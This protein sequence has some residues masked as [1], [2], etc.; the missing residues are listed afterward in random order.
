V[1]DFARPLRLELAPADLALLCREAAAAAATDP[2]P[3]IRVDAEPITVITDAERLRAALINILANA[4]QAT[5]ASAGSA[6]GRGDAVELTAGGS[7]N[8]RVRIAVRDRGAGIPPEHL[9][10]IFEPYFT[11]RRTGTGLGLPIARN[12]IEGLGGSVSVRAAEPGTIVEI[13]LPLAAAEAAVHEAR[14]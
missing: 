4:R 12:I 10:H 11:T 1:L 8:G 2:S 5:V 14:A 9:P 6:E 13:D 3:P 7:A